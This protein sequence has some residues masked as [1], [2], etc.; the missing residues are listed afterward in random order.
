MLPEF[1]LNEYIPYQSPLPKKL[2]RK[3]LLLVEDMK[4]GQV[5]VQLALKNFHVDLEI[6]EDGFEAIEFLLEKPDLDL[7]ILDWRLPGI[8]GLRA[9]NY[10]E[11]VISMDVDLVSAR[12]DVKPIPV[13]IYTSSNISPEQMEGFDHFE[14]VDFWKKPISPSQMSDRFEGLLI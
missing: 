6:A 7:L 13:V 2:K 10:T 11:R 9:L 8:N 12:R 3:R 5:L 4:E 14:V 1:K